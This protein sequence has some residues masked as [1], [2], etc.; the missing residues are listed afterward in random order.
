MRHFHF[1][2]LISLCLLAA[3]T[4]PKEE[5]SIQEAE[6]PK[7]NQI[8]LIFKDPVSNDRVTNPDGSSYGRPGKGREIQFID[9]NHVPQV[10][11]LEEGVA[12]D[13]SIIRSKRDFVEVKLAYRGIDDLTFLFENGDSILFIYDGKKPIAQ[14]L[15]R[16]E[17]YESLNFSLLERDSIAANGYMAY[18]Y[19]HTTLDRMDFQKQRE[20]GLSRDEY[21]AKLSNDGA[22]EVP[23]ETQKLYN[24]LDQLKENRQISDFKYRYR[25][26]NI[27]RS[28]SSMNIRANFRRL[29]RQSKPG[30]ILEKAVADFKERYPEMETGRNDS[31]LFNSMYDRYMRT[32]IAAAHPIKVDV[33]SKQSSGGGA[34][35]R[36]FLQLYD[37]I[38][39]LNFPSPLEKKLLQFSNMSSI[40]SQPD[41]FSITDRLKYLNRFKND[42]KDSAMVQELMTKYDIK[43]E[44][45]DEILLENLEG[46][47]ISFKEIIARHK[48]KLIYVDFWA[49][50]CA[51]CIREMPNSKELQVS[52]VEQDIVYLYLSSDRKAAPWRKSMKEHELNTGLHYRI[53]NANTS[54]GLEDLE[55]FFIPRYMIFDKEGKLV[56][57]DAPRPGEIAEL[58]SIFNNYL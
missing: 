25:L 21:Y 23:I 51:P 35:S 47:T 32:A 29:E 14:V 34:T 20:S 37:S 53:T 24:L 38:R 40:L 4:P 19:S 22:I 56:D 5:Q 10:L 6:P 13:T 49:S 36:D 26:E 52:L 7:A 39:T 54:Q 8:T 2:S 28:L 3:C 48:G 30:E 46:E 16:E 9:D 11:I 41:F 55:I 45:Q 57:D 1:L 27:F 31:L 33:K 43:F 58:K 12:Y 50:W 42:H 18:T 15:N 17:S 44:V